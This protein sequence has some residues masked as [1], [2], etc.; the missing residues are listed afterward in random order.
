MNAHNK[1]YL[2]EDVD[3]KG[4]IRWTIT[5][6]VYLL[7]MS[8]CLFLSAGTRSWTLAW[9]YIG[10]AALILVLDAI[11]LIPISPGLLGERARPQQGAKPWD[12]FL[13]RWMATLGPLTIW[14][15]SGLDFRYSWSAGLP[16]WAIVVSISLVFIGELLVL[17]PM[18]EN[19]FFVGMVRIQTERGHQ[20]INSGPYRFMRHP[21]YLGSIL[22]LTF[23][24]LA[25]D[26]LLGLTPALFTVGVVLLR[27]YLEDQTLIEE[28]DGYQAYTE[29]VHYRLI[30]GL[31]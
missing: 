23:T 31:G 29:Q 1:S 11:V 16:I 19:R 10:V 4:I 3:R 2:R 30:P 21:G 22:Y 28:L 15:V 27:T 17:W 6:V 18:A 13:S 24:P 9:L 12:Q 20:V 8:V 7:L 5:A 25:L 26:S 14:I